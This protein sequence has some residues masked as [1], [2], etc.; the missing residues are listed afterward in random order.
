MADG[1]SW[2]ERDAAVVW[3]GFTQMAAYADNFPVV[4]DRAEGH[5]LYD[6]DGNRYL[7]AISS[8]WVNTLGH[9]VPELDATR[10]RPDRSRRPHHDARQ[11]QSRGG[12]TGRS[13]C[14]S[15][16]GGRSA[17]PVRGRRRQRGGAS[18]QDCVPVLGESG[19]LRAH[20]VPRVRRRLSRR[21]HR[22]AFRG[23]RRL[24][25]RAVR[26]TAL[27]CVTTRRAS[28][29][30]TASR[31]RSNCWSSTQRSSRP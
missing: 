22:R 6:T 16:P 28:P 3:H 23:R 25:N 18:T 4:V 13:P 29:N 19:R 5:Y 27:P 1:G 17:L 9:R 21:H 7:D 30:P 14:S 31:A 24:R 26:P 10:P 8:L 12:G 2:V 11:R 20:W 15:R